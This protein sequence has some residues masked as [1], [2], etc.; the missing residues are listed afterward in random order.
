MFLVISHIFIRKF[1]KIHMIYLFVDVGV[2][3]LNK[4]ISLVVITLFLLSFLINNSSAQEEDIENLV[5]ASFNID[6][7]TA[8]DLLINIT[9]KPYKL[10]MAG[11]TFTSEQIKNANEQDLGSFRLLLF[12]MLESQLKK[13]FINAKI[14][15]FTRPVFDGNSFKE[16]LN[17]ELTSSFYAINESI[18][19]YDFINGILD[20]SALVNYSFTFSAEPGWNNT[21]YVDLGDNLDYQR[22]TGSLHGNKMEWLLNNWKGGNLNKKAEFQIK[23]K[24]PTTKK[25]DSEDIFISYQLN[26]SDSIKTSLNCNV[27]LK[28]INISSYNV[29]PNFV[30]NLNILPSDGIRLFINNK[31][32][33]WDELYQKTV[34]IIEEKL[35]TTIEESKLNQTLNLEFGWDPETTTDIMVPFEVTNMDEFPPL[36]ANIQDSEVDLKIC[37]ISSRALFGLV[38]TNAKVNITKDDI[39]FGDDLEKVG[40]DYNIIFYLPDKMYLDKKNI[41]IWNGSTTAFG[42]FESDIS[43]SYDKDSKETII[44]I[45][46]TNTDLNLLGFF[47]GNTELTF[48]LYFNEI[49][50]YN[51]TKIPSEFSLPDKIKLDYLNSDAI[52]LC[53]EEDVFNQKSIDEFLKNEKEQFESILRLIFPNLQVSGSVKKEIFENSLIWNGNILEMDSTESIVVSSIAKSSYPIPFHLSFLPPKFEIPYQKYNFTG[54]PHHDVTYKIIFPHGIFVDVRD[55]LNKAEV[56]KTSDGRDYILITFS[57]SEANLTDTISCK[58]VPSALFIISVFT[59]CI[60]SFIITIILIVVIFLIRRKRKLKKASKYVE[61]DISDYEDEDYYIPPPPPKK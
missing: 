23:K 19:A 48:A 5:E 59:P 18:N 56:K 31:I 1:Y 40:Y 49:R 17:V 36:K 16:E 46:V 6:F 7:Y 26:S 4:T 39:N 20:M 58:M 10:S 21:Y 27:I 28:K 32:I 13:T 47:T 42:E 34:K 25:L 55:P 41:F 9:V 37:G 2:M 61:E 24:A 45:E 43:N 52:R 50:N 35:K 30:T 29:I 60:L 44:T 3:R 38:N 51:V 8:T 14:L 22:T 57:S 12:Q 53:I 54:I 11:E 15:N 33:S